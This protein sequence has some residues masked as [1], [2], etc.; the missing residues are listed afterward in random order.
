MITET[1]TF[2]ADLPPGY[3]KDPIV[4]SGGDS[5]LYPH[6][7][8]VL[9]S[10]GGEYVAVYEIRYT[11]H[12][13]PFKEASLLGSL[14]GIGYEEYFYLFDV[15]A[16]ENRLIL[17]LEGYFG[18]LYT[19]DHHFYVADAFGLYCIGPTGTVCWHND[20]LG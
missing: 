15:S 13:G 17:L 19:A 9:A 2:S 4:I 7:E 3:R 1:L 6:R 16:G 18:H 12:T 8:Y 20:Q 10:E 5:L 14:L 11:V